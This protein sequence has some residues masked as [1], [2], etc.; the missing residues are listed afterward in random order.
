MTKGE[1]PGSAAR[2]KRGS[3][4][5]IESYIKDLSLELQENARAPSRELPHSLLHYSGNRE[6]RFADEQGLR[7]CSFVSMYSTPFSKT[8][9]HNAC[10][11]HA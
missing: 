9:Y 10:K 5:D 6:N 3:T 8:W 2:I 11:I 4:V 7:H 1:K